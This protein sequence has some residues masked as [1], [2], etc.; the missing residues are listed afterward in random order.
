MVYPL[1]LK[2]CEHARQL[3]E[4]AAESGLRL[5]VSFNNTVLDP[6]SIL[7]LLTLV[8]KNVMLVAPDHS[9]PK[10]FWKLIQ[11]VC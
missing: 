10:D 2:S 6:R 7:G 11:K 4:V 5:T 9:S 1:A 8:G 3:S